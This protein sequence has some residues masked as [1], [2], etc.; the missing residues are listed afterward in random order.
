VTSHE[1]PE[2][3]ERIVSGGAGY[4]VKPVIPRI[5]LEKVRAVLSSR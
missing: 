3:V 2:I 5:L 4:V 1:T